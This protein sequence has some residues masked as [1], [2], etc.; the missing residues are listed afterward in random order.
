[1]GSHQ[2]HNI[3][4]GSPLV[5]EHEQPPPLHRSFQGQTSTVRQLQNKGNDPVIG[6]MGRLV[7]NDQGTAMFGG[8]STGVHFVTQADQQQRVAHNRLDAFPNAV[9]SLY[10]HNIWGAPTSH[11][12]S[13]TIPSIVS[14][15]PPDSEKIIGETISYWAPL[16]PIFHKPSAIDTFRQCFQQPESSD[17]YTVYQALALLSLGTFTFSQLEG[18]HYPTS[19]GPHSPSELYYSLSA[20]LLDAILERPCLQSLQGLVI[21]QIF[22]QVSC[23]HAVASQLGAAAS[24]LAQTL[25]L[26]RHSQRFKFDPL[27]SEIRKRVWWCQYSLDVF[28]RLFTS[29]RALLFLT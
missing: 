12:Y 26:H 29:F 20:T 9:F 23:R 13:L 8:S 2:G 15:F 10:L 19:N 18:S 22:L 21:M 5:A 7:S 1:M 16:Y 3:A 28:V 4:V 11:D 17:I 24:R 25:G 27:S 6:H 14:Q